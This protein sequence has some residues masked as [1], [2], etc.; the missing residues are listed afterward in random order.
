MIIAQLRRKPGIKS[1]TKIELY[2]CLHGNRHLK[3]ATGEMVA[4]ASL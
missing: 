3:L 2:M 4:C 1:L